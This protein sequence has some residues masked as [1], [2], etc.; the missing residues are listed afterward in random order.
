[1][2]ATEAI[3]LT[4]EQ[5]REIGEQAIAD[6]QIERSGGPIETPAGVPHNPS[7]ANVSGDGEPSGSHPR[8]A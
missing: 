5:L 2:L 7:R 3:P 6:D 1:M 8:N 4:A